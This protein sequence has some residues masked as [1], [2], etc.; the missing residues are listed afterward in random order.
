[1]MMVA[2]SVLWGCAQHTANLTHIIFRLVSLALVPIPII[3]FAIGTRRKWTGARPYAAAVLLMPLLL[4]ACGG[5]DNA[6]GGTAIRMSSVETETEPADGEELEPAYHDG[7]V[8]VSQDGRISIESGVMP[9]GGTAPDYW[10]R[11]TVIDSTGTE[12]IIERPYSSYQSSVHAI[13][14]RDG[15]VYYIVE[16]FARL[17]IG[18]AEEWLEAYRIA[19]DGIRQV[20]VADGGEDIDDN[21]FDVIYYIPRRDT[22]CLYRTLEYDSS[23]GDIYVPV[24]EEDGAI[25]DRHVAWHFDGER[26][27][28]QGE[29]DH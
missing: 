13:T 9:G 16:C 14:K 26:F 21:G 22:V 20:N 6:S 2:A 29:R 5:G 28:R 19:G 3:R 4:T 23:A 27:V 15:T 7:D 17:G 25:T 24:T 1:M 8:C 18:C 12:R 10:A 11:W